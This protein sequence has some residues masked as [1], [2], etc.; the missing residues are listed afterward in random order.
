VAA[1]LLLVD[2]W[3]SRTGIRLFVMD[4]LGRLL[5]AAVATLPDHRREWGMAMNAELAEVRGR[6]AR[7]R[8]A[9]S[10]ARIGRR[11]WLEGT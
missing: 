5:A 10:S 6:S 7:W 8:F 11:P 3:W 4:P 2:H 9:L 1:A